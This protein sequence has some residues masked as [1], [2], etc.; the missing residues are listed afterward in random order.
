MERK[1]YI[2]S[3]QE[4]AKEQEL[5]HPVYKFGGNLNVGGNDILNG[6]F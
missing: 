4:L 5:L 2:R 1:R 3:I 6:E